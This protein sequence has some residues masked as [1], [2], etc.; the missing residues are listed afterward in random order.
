MAASA[1]ASATAGPIPG[2][3]AGCRP[4]AA[5]CTP[6]GCRSAAPA[7]EAPQELRAPVPARRGRARGGS[8][9]A[10]AGCSTKTVRGRLRGRLLDHRHGR[11]DGLRRGRGRGGSG[12][13]DGGCELLHGRRRSLARDDRRLAGAGPLVDGRADADGQ[14]NH[15]SDNADHEDRRQRAADEQEWL[16]ALVLVERLGLGCFDL[17]G[18][19]QRVR[20]RLSG[21]CIDG[22]HLGGDACHLRDRARQRGIGAGRGGAVVILRVGEADGGRLHLGGMRRRERRTT[23]QGQLGFV[24]RADGQG[25]QVLQ[26]SLHRARRRRRSRR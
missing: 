7:Q 8:A 14:R 25:H 26:V 21:A 18:I 10:G 22:R 5:G 20:V 17:V 1:T 19:R 3:A 15:Q 12:R 13:R 6:A 9:A 16:A 23:G 24:G 2:A 11:L 4:A